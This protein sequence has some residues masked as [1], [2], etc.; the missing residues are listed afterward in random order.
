MASALLHS[1]RMNANNSPRSYR[2][3]F[4]KQNRATAPV[5]DEIHRL[6]HT[7]RCRKP[8]TYWYVQR[9]QLKIAAP[10]QEHSKFL[11]HWSVYRSAGQHKNRVSRLGRQ[12]EI[13]HPSLRQRGTQ[14]RCPRYCPQ[15]SS[16]QYLRL[17]AVAQGFHG[18][19]AHYSAPL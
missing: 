15:Q 1:Y 16:M 14:N 11:Q 17:R 13:P 5:V 18:S 3:R 9:D 12:D 7:E 4:L 2:L 6:A 10:L 8:R 19:I